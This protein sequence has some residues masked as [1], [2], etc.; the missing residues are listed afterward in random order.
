[1]TK[2]LET[3]FAQAARLSAEEQDA[4]AR[5]VMAELQSEA[6]WAAAF[7]SSQHELASLA[8]EAAADYK[9]GRTRPF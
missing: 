8:Q 1:M 9:A 2:L 7:A 5:F 6:K 4:F 3:V